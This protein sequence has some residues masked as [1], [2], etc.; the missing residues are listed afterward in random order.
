M[1]DYASNSKKYSYKIILD[2][3]KNAW[4]WHNGYN[5]FSH[6]MDWG[7]NIPDDIL[8]KIR[9]K[10]EKEAYAFLIPFLK[11]K[12]IDDKDK[13]KTS[14]NFIENQFKEKFKKACLKLEK[15]VGKP[16]YRNDFTIYLTTFPR[17][18]YNYYEGYI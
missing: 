3:E 1:T 6:G 11:Q 17:G 5:R 13:I 7:K 4:N 10:P 15:V 14:T 18:P 9:G 12:Y 8:M 16:I 2:L